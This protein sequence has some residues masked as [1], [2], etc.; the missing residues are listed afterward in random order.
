LD[1]LIVLAA[2]LYNETWIMHLS[3]ILLLILTIAFIAPTGANEIDLTE[4]EVPFADTRPRDPFVDSLG[5][6]WFC[7]Q[8]GA[9]IASMDPRTGVFQ[10]F[11]LSDGA[12]PH[13][14]IIDA[15][16]RIWYAA[17]T[18]PYI[19][20]LDPKRGE[21]KKFPMPLNSARDPHTLTFDSSGN[22]WFSAQW[23]DMIGRLNTE[24]GKVDLF[25]LPEKGLRPYGIT[26]D[27]K[28]R[29]WIALFGSNQLGLIYPRSKSVQLI[30]LPDRRSRPRRVEV[31]KKGMIWFGDYRLG[32]LGRYDPVS[33]HFQE[34]QLPG[35]SDSQPYGM[36]IDHRNHIWLAEGGNPNRL[37][38]FD[39]VKQAFI[40]ITEISNARGS[41]RH[42]YFD[43]NDQSIWFGEDSNFIGRVRLR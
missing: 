21:L 12:N 37:V 2:D 4:W 8:G 26:V 5:R 24:N 36:A 23:S 17:N 41:I 22:I 18:L 16:D 42:M 31:G 40:S 14:L 11:P 34:W 43:A 33:G 3:K 10:K 38:E 15:E 30:Q 32:Y 29:V 25:K 1:F 19:G 9:Y 6:V 39:P 13:N 35:G 20:R 7:G 28:D 27:S